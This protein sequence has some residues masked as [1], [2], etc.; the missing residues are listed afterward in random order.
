VI[1]PYFNILTTVI[2]KMEELTGEITANVEIYK[3]MVDEQEELM[4]KGNKDL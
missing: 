1:H 4:K 2:P 3:T